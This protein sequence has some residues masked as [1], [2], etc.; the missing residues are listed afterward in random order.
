M[1]QESAWDREYRQ[2]QL[3]TKDNKPQADVVRFVTYLKKEQGI[4]IGGTTVLDLGSGTGRNSYYFAELGASVTGFEISKT[5]IT[6]GKE[7]AD[8]AGLH[9]EY[10]KQSIGDIFPIA[11]SSVDIMLD[12]TSSNSLSERE[13]E[14]YL[15]ETHRVLRSGGYFFVKALCKDGDQNAKHLL[16]HSKGEEKDTYILPGVGITERVWTKNDFVSTYEK[17]FTI[18]HLEKKTSY[19]RMN[20]RSYKRN[21]WLAYMKK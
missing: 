4:D 17:Y 12:I 15:A 3:L 8:N 13:R 10:K 21:F 1:A 14:I 18:M 11:D 5:A 20:N 7:N 9:I 16:E 6:I 2:S 19:S